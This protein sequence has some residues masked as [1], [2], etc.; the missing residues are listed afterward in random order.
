MAEDVCTAV[1]ENKPHQY[2]IDAGIIRRR[3]SFDHFGLFT[4]TMQRAA[5]GSAARRKPDPHPS[6]VQSAAQTLSR[7]SGRLKQE[8]NNFLNSVRVA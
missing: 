4:R 5:R 7:D 3:S 8:V 6:Q 2:R 1:R